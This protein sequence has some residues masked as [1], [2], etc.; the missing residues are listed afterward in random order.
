M[1]NECFR[2]VMLACLIACLLAWLLAIAPLE[3]P[4][5]PISLGNVQ[6][7]ACVMGHHLQGKLTFVWGGHSTLNF[8][9]D[10]EVRGVPNSSWP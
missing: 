10:S 6:I 5:N 8:G 7:C 1:K 9:L 2:Q 3:L 4:L